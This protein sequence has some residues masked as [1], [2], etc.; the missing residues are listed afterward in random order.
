MTAILDILTR[1]D[2]VQGV[3]IV[4]LSRDQRLGNRLR[5]AR[6]EHR[7]S[8]QEL[9]RRAG[10]TR[11]T[12]SAIENGQYCPS[13]LLAFQL[14]KQLGKRAL[15]PPGDARPELWINEVG[16]APTH[17]RKGIGKLLIQR[18]LEEAKNAGCTE[19]WVLTDRG[20]LAAMAL[21]KSVGGIEDIPDQTMFTFEL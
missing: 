7:L 14:A 10:V 21:Y 17:H 6:A 1:K 12:I 5:V 16:V 11:Q 20:N 4:Q 9:A 8:Q 2:Y 18:T 19:A 15:N 3:S 13:A